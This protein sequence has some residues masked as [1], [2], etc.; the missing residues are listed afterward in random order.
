MAQQNRQRLLTIG[1]PGTTLLVVNSETEPANEKSKR[2]RHSPKS[3]ENSVGVFFAFT[4]LESTLRTTLEIAMASI[5][6]LLPKVESHVL[7]YRAAATLFSVGSI[8][9]GQELLQD[10]S[11][12]LTDVGAQSNPFWTLDVNFPGYRLWN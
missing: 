5:V 2:Q 10:P 8:A 1:D 7:E 4:A 9:V 12:A 3:G 6:S 11:F